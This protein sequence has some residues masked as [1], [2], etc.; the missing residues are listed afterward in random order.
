MRYVRFVVAQQHA[1][2]SR[3]SGLIHAAERMRWDF[4]DDEEQEYKPLYDWFSANLPVP[5]RFARATRS[6]AHGLALSWFKDNAGECIARMRAVGTILEQRDV[7]VE[8]LRTTRP[9]FIVYEDAFQVAAEP[10]ADTP[11]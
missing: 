11:T 7:M 9:G 8:M 2:S 3:R 10:F 5:D 6:H 4:S 1:Q